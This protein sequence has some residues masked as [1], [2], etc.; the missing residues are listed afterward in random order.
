MSKIL[1]FT[2]V[3][4]NNMI[5]NKN[6][7]VKFEKIFTSAPKPTVWETSKAFATML[8][9]LEYLCMLLQF[10]FSGIKRPNL[11]LFW[12]DN[13]PVLTAIYM[14]T[15]FAKAG[16]VE[17]CPAQSADLNLNEHIRNELKYWLLPRPPHLTS[18]PDLTSMIQC[19][20]M[21]KFPEPTSQI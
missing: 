8:N 15:W 21:Y 1:H 11:N 18:D 5:C 7:C 12:H 10:P 6:F 14:K 4:D 9:C 17:L 16:V 3:F 20:G 2:Q 19:L 13:D